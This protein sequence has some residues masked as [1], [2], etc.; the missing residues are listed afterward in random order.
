MREE[1]GI[2]ASII[3]TLM[4]WNQVH[5][6]TKFKLEPIS[7]WNQVKTQALIML[8]IGIRVP[9]EAA[10]G[11]NL[12]AATV[13]SKARG[14]HVSFLARYLQLEHRLSILNSSINKL[15]D[16]YNNESRSRSPSRRGPNST[17]A[18]R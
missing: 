6:G 8:T 14:E 12:G 13:N 3:G 10:E 7:H 2:Y 11:T 17:S 18:R 5:I 16:H 1:L 4:P 9:L 15:V